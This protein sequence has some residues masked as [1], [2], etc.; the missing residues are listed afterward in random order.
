MKNNYRQH[1]VTFLV[2][3]KFSIILFAIVSS[4]SVKSL[5]MKN[6]LASCSLQHLRATESIV[7]KFS[8]IILGI[9]FLDLQMVSMHIEKINLIWKMIQYQTISSI[10]YIISLLNTS[11]RCVHLTLLEFFRT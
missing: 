11:T 7:K 1:L 4:I 6:S 10:L 8:N 9:V 2:K 5:F 3:V